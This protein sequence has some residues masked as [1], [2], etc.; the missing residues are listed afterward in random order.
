MQTFYMWEYMKST[1]KDTISKGKC[2]DFLIKGNMDND[3]EGKKPKDYN[4]LN[5]RYLD[6]LIAKNY[7]EVEDKIRGEISLTKKGQFAVE[8]FSVFYGIDSKEFA[9]FSK[10]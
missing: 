1:K 3:F 8:V 2:V 4:R 9:K 7:I 5:F 6:K 10:H